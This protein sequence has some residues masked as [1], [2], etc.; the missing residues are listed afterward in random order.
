MEAGLILR[1]NWQHHLL[2]ARSELAGKNMDDQVQ[3]EGHKSE[4]E[5]V[6][7][8]KNPTVARILALRKAPSEYRLAC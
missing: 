3:V 2:D 8:M 5:K 1:K 7:V 6:S 4:I